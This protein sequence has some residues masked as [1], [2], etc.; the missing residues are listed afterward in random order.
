VEG[1][2]AVVD[3]RGWVRRVGGGGGRGGG[4]GGFEGVGGVF[5][6]WFWVRGVREG[7]EADC[8]DGG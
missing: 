5:G 2:R 7:D 3:V 4:R 1:G 6:A 8:A